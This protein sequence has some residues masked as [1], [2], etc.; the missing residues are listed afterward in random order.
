[1]LGTSPQASASR[2]GC[3]GCVSVARLNRPWF[4]RAVRRRQTA[5][6]AVVAAPARQ[7]HAHIHR[8]GVDVARTRGQAL[9]R[10][11]APR[12]SRR[13]AHRCDGTL[14]AKL[15][16]LIVDIVVHRRL[17]AQR[18]D[19]A[20]TAVVRR[21]DAVDHVPRVARTAAVAL[22]NSLSCTMFGTSPHASASRPGCP[23]CVSVAR[24]N[25]PWFRR[26]VRRR[27]TAVVDCRRRCRPPGSDPTFTVKV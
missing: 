23:G 8:Q 26:S 7:V 5:V 4:R 14:E 15:A 2:P 6:V 22:T 9:V 24:L 17:V 3:P 20:R 10:R 1:M 27:Q 18:V 13:P 12:A 16:L 25:R 21:R 11:Q 19:A